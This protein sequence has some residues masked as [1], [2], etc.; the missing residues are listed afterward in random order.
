MINIENILNKIS[1]NGFKGEMI[2]AR[3]CQ[4]I[5]LLLI[6]KSPFCKNVTIKGGVV[7]SSISRDIRRA[8]K[9]VDFDFIK[10]PLND[11]QIRIFLKLLN[12]IEGIKIET[13]RIE[14]LKHQDYKGRRV[15]IKICDVYKNIL[16]GKLDIGVHKHCSLKQREYCF[17][18]FACED[19]VSLLINSP[20]QIFTEKLKSLIRHDVFSTRFKDVFDMYFLLDKID[21]S[22]LL[23]CFDILIYDDKQLK[24][25]NVHGVYDKILSIFTDETY[26]LNIK[27][28]KRNWVDVDVAIILETILTFL[29]D[30]S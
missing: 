20:E 22:E 28:S 17:D 2:D 23:H 8:T 5:I 6:S 29:S 16:Y 1:N 14:E 21:R 9:D 25:K 19:T 27:T 10:L 3:A 12:G 15:Y 18:I 11:N 4:D 13:I 7:L 24:I 26:V 30:L